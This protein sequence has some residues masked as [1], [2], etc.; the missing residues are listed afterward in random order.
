MRPAGPTGGYA[1]HQSKPPSAAKPGGTECLGEDFIATGEA[2]INHW[3][4]LRDFKGSLQ[5]NLI[6]HLKHYGFPFIFPLHQSIESRSA[7][8]PYL[9]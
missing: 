4:G 7:A 5:E 3:I 2:S 1:P 8:Q 6:F 9:E